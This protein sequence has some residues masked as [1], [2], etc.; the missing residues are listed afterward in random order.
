[1][2]SPDSIYG[3]SLLDKDLSLFDLSCSIRASEMRISVLGAVPL[4]LLLVSFRLDHSNGNS[5]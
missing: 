3:Y 5:Y 4:S 2:R 1:M